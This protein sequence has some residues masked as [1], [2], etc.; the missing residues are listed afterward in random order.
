MQA[1][2]EAFAIRDERTKQRRELTGASARV[3]VPALIDPTP[4]LATY[5]LET[6]FSKTAG[7]RGLI[8]QV[9][10]GTL[11]EAMREVERSHPNGRHGWH[12]RLRLDELTRAER[13]RLVR[14]IVKRAPKAW[15][16]GS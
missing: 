11:G 5:K 10:K 2:A 3:L 15:R 7:G 1:L 8:V 4:E 9:G 13:E 6:L 16:A 12:G 14:A